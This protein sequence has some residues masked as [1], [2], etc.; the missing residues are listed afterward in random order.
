MITRLSILKCGHQNWS[1]SA[2]LRWMRAKS[3]ADSSAHVTVSPIT[4][5][6]YKTSVESPHMSL[7]WELQIL[8]DKLSAEFSAHVTVL[9]IT[10]LN[11]KLPA[12][13][14]AH[15]NVPRITNFKLQII[16]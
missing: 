11:Y 5:L 4:N 7:C 10:N 16:S 15:V 1:L 13:F 3:S 12:E 14:P 9:K 6:D 2:A 8:N